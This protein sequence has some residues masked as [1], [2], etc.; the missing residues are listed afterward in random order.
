MGAHQV[1]TVWGIRT[2]KSLALEG[3]KRHQRD[4]RVA[5][6]VD[7]RRRFGNLANLPQTIVNPFE[8]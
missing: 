7:A 1:E 3:L 6:V 5:E 8:S 4:Q 2:I